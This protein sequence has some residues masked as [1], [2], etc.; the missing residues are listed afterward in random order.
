MISLN[1]L[2]KTYGRGADA[3]TV[4]DRLNFKVGAG[5]IFAVTGPSGA[6]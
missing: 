3:V 6:G 1:E 5:E 4:L 2:T